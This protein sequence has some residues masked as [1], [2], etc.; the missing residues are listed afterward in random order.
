MISMVGSRKCT[1]YGLSVAYRFSSELAR[2]GLVIVSGMARG[3]DSMSHRGAL[4]AGGIT[5]AVLGCG[6]DV[7]YPPE[8]KVLM[9]RIQERGCIISEYPPGTKPALG[10]FPSRN[11]IIS[12]MSRATVVVEAGRKSGTLI[13]VDQALN[14]GREVMAVPGNITSKLSE[15]T[16]R[17]IRQGAT[18]VTSSDDI[19]EQ[20]G[21]TVDLPIENTECA[22]AP[23]EKLVYDCIGLDPTAIENIYDRLSSQPGEL[24]YV[25]TLLEMRKLIRRLP[26]QRVVR[27]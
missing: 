11:R 9:R 1:E 5:A 20:L 3:V 13:T 26:G 22:L 8:N 7:C 18:P 24:N 27:I 6:A 2:A 21:L 17:L 16:N 14:E 23:A 10:Y 15:G 19:L 4:D 12:G 25:L